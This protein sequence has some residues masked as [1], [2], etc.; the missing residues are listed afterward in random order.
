M[1]VISFLA[2]LGPQYESAKNLLLTSA[3]L[4]ALNAT[5]FRLSRL[6]VED[7]S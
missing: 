7:I 6:F 2:A 3:D 5:F 1:K 4:P